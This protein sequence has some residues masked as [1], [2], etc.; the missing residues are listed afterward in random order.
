M[1][2]EK[3]YKTSEALRRAVRKYNSHRYKNDQEYQNKIKE[4]ATQ[5]TKTQYQNNEEYREK[6]KKYYREAYHKRKALKLQQEQDR[7]RQT[8]MTIPCC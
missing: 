4:Q 1:T 8:N 7:L 3:E 5:W 2:T 6:M